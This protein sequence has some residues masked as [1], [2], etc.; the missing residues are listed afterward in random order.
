MRVATVTLIS[1]VC[2]TSVHLLDVRAFLVCGILFASSHLRITVQMLAETLIVYICLLIYASLVY[3]VSTAS[4]HSRTIKQ[5]FAASYYTEC[6]YMLESITYT[7]HL[8]HDV[9]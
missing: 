6:R 8:H 7:Q 5:M 2:W 3:G 9:R 4:S 1:Y